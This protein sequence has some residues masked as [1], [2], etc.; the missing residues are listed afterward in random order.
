MRPQKITFGDVRS[1]GL[2]G[3]LVYCADYRCSHSV[4]LAADRWSDDVRLSDIEPR[5]VCSA[6]GHHGA[7]VRPDWNAKGPIGCMGYPNTR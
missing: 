3:I 6:C 2:R 5:F 7:E 4:A 1:M